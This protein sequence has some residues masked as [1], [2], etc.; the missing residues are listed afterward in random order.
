MT[1][2]VTFLAIWRGRHRAR[3]STPGEGAA[4]R[5]LGAVAA[6][7]RYLANAPA[8]QVTCWRT[9]LFV[10]PAGG[11]S[12]LL[13]LF[14]EKDL[15]AGAEAYGFLLAAVGAGS[16]GG[17]L[18]L[19][20]LRDRFHLDGMLGAATALS[21]SCTLLLSLVHEHILAALTLAGTGAAWLAGVTALN[22]GAARRSPRG[23]WPAPL[24][25]T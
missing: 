2:V 15:G 6:G 18:V 22:L 4:E 25:P 7:V 5:M 11:L 3:L 24:V 19:P 9:F 1:T 14:A 10:L 13:P 12:A 8:L 23:L 21:A 20:K 16:V 17:A